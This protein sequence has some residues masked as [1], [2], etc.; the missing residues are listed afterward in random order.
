MGITSQGVKNGDYFKMDARKWKAAHLV[1]S[2][3]LSINKIAAEI[4]V[5]EKTIDIWKRHPDFKAAVE[6]ILAESTKRILSTGIARRE[7]RINALNDRWGR[8]TA[9]I[10]A[11][12]TDPTMEGIPGGPT[13]TLVRQLKSVGFGENNQIIEEYAFDRALFA[14]LREHE[15][16]AAYELDQWG[17][18]EGGPLP[19]KVIVS[20]ADPDPEPP[21]TEPVEP[22][23]TTD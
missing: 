22:P 12:S 23:K 10:E 8:M 3:D 1:A 6:E 14:E 16:Q 9:L 5:A 11:R 13:G 15:K 18:K 17:N 7:N 20:W 2:G 19:E 21:K 4:G